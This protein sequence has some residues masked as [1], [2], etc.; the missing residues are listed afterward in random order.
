MGRIAH[1]KRVKRKLSDATVDAAKALKKAG[2]EMEC[3]AL[4]LWEELPEWQ[5]DG[6]QYIETGYR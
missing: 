4:L 6:N 5:Q 1:A 3:V 2:K